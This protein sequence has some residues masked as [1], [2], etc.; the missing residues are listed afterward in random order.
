LDFVGVDGCRAGWFWIG[1]DPSGQHRNGIVETTEELAAIAQVAKLVLIDIPIGLR[2]SGTQERLCDLE[3]RRVLGVPRGSSVFPAP[4]RPALNARSYEEACE[5]NSRIRGK[6]LSR[7]TWGIAKKIRSIDELLISRPDLRAI[8]RESHPEVCF[9]SLNGKRPMSANKKRH[10]GRQERLNVLKRVFPEA[11]SVVE[12]AAKAYRRKDL[13]WDDI[14][15]ALTLAV[16]ARLG[17]GRLRTL[18]AIPERDS[19]DL[20]MEIVFAH[21]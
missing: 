14:I 9:W 16:T 3:A 18:P 7:Q 20:P 10:A 4:T 19:F 13:A 2:D 1:L 6:R 12:A 11:E 5:I 21:F 8:V 15:D 17:C